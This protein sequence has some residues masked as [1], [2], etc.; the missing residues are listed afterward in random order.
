M[1]GSAHNNDFWTLSN[2][3]PLEVVSR[4]RDPQLHV[5]ENYSC[6]FNLGSNIRSLKPRLLPK[7]LPA[8]KAG[9]RN[10]WLAKFFLNSLVLGLF[11]F[12]RFASV[13]YS[14]V[15]GKILHLLHE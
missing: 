12:L 2:F 9:D 10:F 4:Y 8:A 13:V 15:I 5:G 11:E 14:S 3:H 6:S 7:Y 1:I